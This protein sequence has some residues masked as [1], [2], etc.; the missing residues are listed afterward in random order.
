MDYIE[1][2][3]KCWLE[4]YLAAQQDMKNRTATENPYEA[5]NR[6]YEHSAWESGNWWYMAM[7]H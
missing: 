5:P 7:V 2:H 1:V 4:G 6:H 3:N